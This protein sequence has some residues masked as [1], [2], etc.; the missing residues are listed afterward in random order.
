M[1]AADSAS[2]RRHYSLPR[3]VSAEMA[4]EIAHKALPRKRP[5]RGD[6]MLW[7]P[8]LRPCP[9][10]KSTS[11]NLIYQFGRPCSNL[12]RGPA[13]GFVKYYA[14]PLQVD[15]FPITADVTGMATMYLLTTAASFG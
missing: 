14:I 15:I 3:N 8:K 6:R 7:L 11:I 9:R 4:C 10:Q 13:W 1:T 12:Y 5:V 2:E